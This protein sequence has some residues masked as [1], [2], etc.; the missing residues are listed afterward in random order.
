MRLEPLELDIVTRS[1]ARVLMGSS[2]GPGRFPDGSV[3]P[4]ALCSAREVDAWFALVDRFTHPLLPDRPY[5]VIVHDMLHKHVPETFNPIIFKYLEEG[6]RPTIDQA[7][8]IMTTST[9]TRLDVI[10]EYGVDPA[11]V[12]LVPVAYEPH[13]RFGGLAAQ[14]VPVP[15]PFILNPT[16]AA[17]H[18][19]AVPLLRAY[20]RLRARLGEKTPALVLC[21]HNTEGFDPDYA[22]KLDD[23]Y[24]ESIRELVEG[25]EL[26]V[27]RDLYLLGRVEDACLADLYHACAVVVNAALYDNGTYSIIEGHYFG[28]PVLSAR[29]PAAEFLYGRFEVPVHFFGP[30]NV[31][32]LT[33]QLEHALQQ[34]PLAGAALAEV[35]RRLAEP[36]HSYRR[37]AEQV[38]DLLVELRS[39]APAATPVASLPCGL[40]CREKTEWM[41]LLR[42]RPRVTTPGHCALASGAWSSRPRPRPR[43][44]RTKASASSSTTSWS[45][46]LPRRVLPR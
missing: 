34:E 21:G 15:E 35:R 24:W 17:A 27:G 29:Y 36:Q 9:A 38:Y 30:R 46:C 18:K 39:R 32:A 26:Q 13:R 1:C 2:P 43:S 4:A 37:Y 22:G 11:K 3:R 20:S 25:L 40:I 6:I 44:C 33:R 28:K 12:R 16:N 8:L 41:H 7:R 5:G 31:P 10:E 19:G 14:H 23:K 42:G 45:A